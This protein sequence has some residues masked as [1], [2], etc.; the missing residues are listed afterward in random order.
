MSIDAQTRYARSSMLITDVF[1]EILRQFITVQHNNMPAQALERMVSRDKEFRNTL[2]ADERKMIQSLQ[3]GNYDEIDFS[4]LYKLIRYFKLVDEPTKSWGNTPDT[5]DVNVGD[6]TERLRRYRNK[7]THKTRADMTEI[8]LNKLFSDVTD[9]GKRAD[10]YLQKQI[11]EKEIEKLRKCSMD[12]DIKEKYIKLLEKYL[13]LQEMYKTNK[14]NCK[15]YLGKTIIKRLEDGTL[16]QDE[17]ECML[18]L[19]KVKNETDAVHRINAIKDELNKG[20]YKVVLLKVEESSV[21][22]KLSVHKTAFSSKDQFENEILSF[23]ERLFGYKE[24]VELLEKE[25]EFLISMSD[26]N[27][28]CNKRELVDAKSKLEFDPKSQ[29]WLKLNLQMT[30]TDNDTERVKNNLKQFLDNLT[31]LDSEILDSNVDV[32]LETTENA[33]RPYYLTLRKE[34]KLSIATDFM[35][36]ILLNN[37]LLFTDFK[38]KRLIIFDIDG[39]FIR[40]IILHNRPESIAVVRCMDNT[41]ALTF[42]EDKQIAIMD[43][44]STETLKMIKV[45]GKCWGISYNK[46]FLYVAIENMIEVLFVGDSFEPRVEKQKFSLP[47]KK[48]KAALRQEEII[49][50]VQTKAI[51]PYSAVISLER[52]YGDLMMQY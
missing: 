6:D 21:L 5:D 4:L 49:Y 12:E 51:I 8:E 34:I 2:D 20:N 22:L 38:D 14:T 40:E 13:D 46:N 25:A 36:G 39:K 45:S 43:V 3:S 47:T 9:I 37:Q 7:I 10:K 26:Y 16:E 30:D 17:T 48:A 50:S 35:D 27:I 52:L 44:T 41:I 42:P 18:Y 23:L 28:P 15:I 31:M 29:N 1:P 33:G 11:F 19:R 32:V 24:V